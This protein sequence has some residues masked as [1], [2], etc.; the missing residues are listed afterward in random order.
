[1]TAR[2]R[3]TAEG[4]VKLVALDISPSAWQDT[5]TGR[6][7]AVGGTPYLYTDG[8]RLRAGRP[9]AVND[10][11]GPYLT[12][13]GDNP[14]TLLP[15]AEGAGGEV[16]IDSTGTLVPWEDSGIDT[17]TKAMWINEGH[18]HDQNS[19]EDGV[20]MSV[21]PDHSRNNNAEFIHGSDITEMDP[22]YHY[23]V[24]TENI[25]TDAVIFVRDE[26]MMVTLQSH[27]IDQPE[28]LVKQMLP[29][30][31]TTILKH[32]AA[33]YALGVAKRC[34]SKIVANDADVEACKLYVAGD[35]WD[36]IGHG[37]NDKVA[38]AAITYAW[39]AR[40][41]HTQIVP[42][43]QHQN[44]GTRDRTS[45]IQYY[46][47]TTYNR[48]EAVSVVTG[49]GIANIWQPGPVHA[50]ANESSDGESDSDVEPE[51]AGGS[52]FAGGSVFG[53]AVATPN[54]WI[55]GGQAVGPAGGPAGGQAKNIQ[56][57]VRKKAKPT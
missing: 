12:A 18:L 24:A 41:W 47:P 39:A 5:P 53:M 30:D 28:S 54:P 19:T 46:T 26:S 43:E 10:I 56:G 36:S 11:I 16:S 3:H 55:A 34:T 44:P 38:F 7:V 22:Q 45:T 9:F 8:D 2:Y 13:G 51:L 37:D 25:V 6:G 14:G 31:P 57:L 20:Y 49:G 48:A 35:H 27:E 23:V 15:F 40:G 52:E 32:G 42:G 29:N 50:P 33:E 21:T 4:Y 17:Q 1:M